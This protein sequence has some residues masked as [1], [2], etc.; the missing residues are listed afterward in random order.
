[1]TLTSETDLDMVTMNQHEKYYGQRSFSSQ[2]IA[3]TDKY[4]HIMNR[5]LS[6]DQ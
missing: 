2:A 5:L 3:R 6:V 4:T 1:M